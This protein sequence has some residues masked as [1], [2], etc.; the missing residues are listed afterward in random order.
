MNMIRW[1]PFDDMNRL[2]DQVNRLFEQNVTQTGREAVPV[3]TWSPAVDITETDS[4]IILDIELA[5][6]SP[7]EI[8]IQ[9][10]EE[11]LT[12]RGDRKTVVSE[13]R[14]PLRTERQYGPFQRSFTLGMPIQ[15][16]AV[17]AS[18]REGILEITLPKKEE[19]P[20]KQVKV[21]VQAADESPEI[22]AG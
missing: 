16:D 14:R 20:P 3:H 21:E 10:T 5:G 1:D 4:A 17:N 11:T 13:G 9:I 6:I 15:R 22:P 18:Y 8:D 2:W 19:A 7:K 12:I